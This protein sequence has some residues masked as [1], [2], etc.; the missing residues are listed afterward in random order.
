MGTKKKFWFSRAGEMWLFK[1]TRPGSGE[2]WAEVLAAGLAEILGLPH[3]RY[4]LAHWRDKGNVDNA[5]VVTQRFTPNGF[6]LVHGNEL[7]AE[8]DPSYPAPGA[9]YV[10][11]QEHN[12]DF[13]VLH[14]FV[15]AGRL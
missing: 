5:G 6:D 13:E 15:P 10:R 7:L 11:T 12:P 3:A 2:H 4:E 14:S 9:R 1:A 8:R